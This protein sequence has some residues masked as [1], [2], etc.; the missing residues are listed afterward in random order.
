MT[1]PHFVNRETF[2][3]DITDFTIQKK[4]H[5]LRVQ[6]QK[7]AIFCGFEEKYPTYLRGYKE[8]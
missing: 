5:I 3:K 2:K 7:I 4:T 6:P 8:E 1:T